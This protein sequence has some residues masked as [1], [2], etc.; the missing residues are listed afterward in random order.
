[1]KRSI[2]ALVAGLGM[3]GLAACEK[4]AET[5]APQTGGAAGGAK[6]QLGKAMEAGKDTAKALENKSKEVAAEAGNV[7]NDAAKKLAETA[8]KQLDEWKPKVEELK[9]KA[10]GKI[11]AAPMV[12][13]VDAAWS[14]LTGELEKIKAGGE[15]SALT[16][17]WDG[18]SSKFK[19]A[20]T[21]LENAVK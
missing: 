3:I 1:M 10:E 21:A 16:K 7:M 11:T 6:S 15:V 20:L 19:D 4:K 14:G 2:V 13:A 9:K 8:Q 5:P 17:A 12:K 18:A